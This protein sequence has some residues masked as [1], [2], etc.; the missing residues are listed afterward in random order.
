MATK[1]D[2]SKRKSRRQRRKQ[3]TRRKVI[4]YSLFAIASYIVFLIATFPASLAV[5]MITSNPD[6]Q[7]KLKI[8]AVS[9]TVWSGSAA[10][11][12]VSG[13]NL[14]KVKWELSFLPILIGDISS[15]VNFKNTSTSASNISGSG[16]IVATLGG[17]L[18]LEDFS[19][20]FPVDALTPFMYGMPARFS[21]DV[22][23]H[24]DE[25]ELEPG[26]RINLKSKINVA[27]A[28]LS[29]PQKITYGDIIIK[30]NPK[31][32]G[33]QLVLNDQGGPLILDGNI[34]IKGNGVYNINLA[35][36]ARDTASKDLENGLRFLGRRDSTGKYQYRSN[37]KFQNW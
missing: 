21:G 1:K 14:G 24:I 18:L 28:G 10:S 23:L 7:N 9:G 20:A 22:R 13:V 31:D 3:N 12:R 29:S 33:S 6:L 2:S 35:M 26:K 32:A 16:T 15:Y 30:S 8:S 11:V 27:N 17:N 5:S 34:K 25:M 37:G 19:A 4:R 36:G